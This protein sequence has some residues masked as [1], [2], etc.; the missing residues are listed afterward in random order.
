MAVLFYGTSGV[1]G[2]FS[3][4]SNHEVNLYGA[5]WPTSEHA[6]QAM[7]FW[8]HR[9]DLIV[10]IRALSTPKEAAA[11]GRNR[12]NPIHKDWDNDV[13]SLRVSRLPDAD[14]P[15]LQ[16]EDG[17]RHQEGLFNRV[18][19]VIMYE[20]C[21]AKFT[22]H[23]ALR[24]LLMNTRGHAIIEESKRDSYWGWGADHTGENKL[25]RV[26]MAI[27]DSLMEGA[28]TRT[29]LGK[30]DRVNFICTADF[31]YRSEFE[32]GDHPEAVC[33]GRV[34]QAYDT[35]E[36]PHCGHYYEVEVR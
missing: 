10:A 27:R 16:P 23:P 19:D 36:C 21:Y 20:I 6:F 26:L 30:P 13:P 31:P 8:P 18:K 33:T 4:F 17:L 12:V 7:K 32:P 11:A 3:N 15:L 14:H 5:K 34:G 24:S 25:G 28:Q 2:G 29:L 22:Q 9:P 35:Y 1:H